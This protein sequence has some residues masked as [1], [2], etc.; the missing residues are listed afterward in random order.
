MVCESVF[1]WGLNTLEAWIHQ[2]KNKIRYVSIPGMYV[3]GWFHMYVISF[4]VLHIVFGVLLAGEMDSQHMM[5]NNQNIYVLNFF[6]SLIWL[7]GQYP[8]CFNTPIWI[9]QVVFSS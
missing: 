8:S 7:F 5:Y 2:K 9:Y 4:L 6:L 3:G 1:Q